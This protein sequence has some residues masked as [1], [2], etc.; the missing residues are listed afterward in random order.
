L[1]SAV[2]ISQKKLKKNNDWYQL[3]PGEVGID[4]STSQ[5][6]IALNAIAKKVIQG[7]RYDRNS[8]FISTQDTL[9]SLHRE[10][11]VRIDIEIQDIDEKKIN[12]RNPNEEEHHDT[13]T[14]LLEQI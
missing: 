9:L 7:F 10:K 6:V 4:Y 14:T 8:D 5:N 1:L 11:R 3:L 13:F 12:F 2:R